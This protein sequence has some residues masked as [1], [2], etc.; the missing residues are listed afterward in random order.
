M[1]LYSTD[2]VMETNLQLSHFKYY[3][4]FFSLVK[5]QIDKKHKRTVVLC[6]AIW[7]T[8]HSPTLRE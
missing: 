8:A 6:L 7:T 2:I 1:A 4:Q 5:V 3:Q